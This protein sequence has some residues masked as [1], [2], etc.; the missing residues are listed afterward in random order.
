MGAE[1]GVFQLSHAKQLPA[2]HLRAPR[3]VVIHRK[4]HH[5]FLHETQRPALRVADLQ[6][7]DQR[8]ANQDK[9]HGKLKHHQRLP[10]E[11]RAAAGLLEL[12]EHR[13]RRKR[14]EVKGRI[15]PRQQRAQKAHR[16]Q[17]AIMVRVGKIEREAGVDKPVERRQAET[18]QHQRHKQGDERNQPRLAHELL[19]QSRTPAA[20]CFPHAHLQRPLLRPRG[21]EVH[22]VDARN[23]QDDAANPEEQPHRADVAASGF[24]PVF[25][26]A[27]EPHPVEGIYKVFVGYIAVGFGDRQPRQFL[28]ELRHVRA[29]MQF[30]QRVMPIASPVGWIEMSPLNACLFIQPEGYHPVVLKAVALAE[31]LKHTGY[32][33]RSAIRVFQRFAQRRLSAEERRRHLLAN[34]NGVVCRE[35]P[36]RRAFYKRHAEH[37]EDAA[38]GIHAGHRHRR[39]VAVF[40][41]SLFVVRVARVAPDFGKLVVERLKQRAGR[42]EEGARLVAIPLV[43]PYPV[44]VLVLRDVLVEVNLIFHPQQDERGGGYPNGQPRDVEDAVRF[45]A[46]NN[47]QR[48]FDVHTS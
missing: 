24:L 37:P 27:V 33:I 6:I 35:R 13:E 1:T 29:G 40:Q 39:E 44:K 18:G 10:Y 26:F 14:R 16:Q 46:E 25:K 23:E 20:E 15:T 22:K 45:V 47:P 48:L 5:V 11:R 36:V 2:H 4:Q 30:H 38:V 17:S 42:H 28:V 31:I 8:G 32:F 34:H 9:R 7:D 12:L 43:L 21:G 19:H 41:K 3:D